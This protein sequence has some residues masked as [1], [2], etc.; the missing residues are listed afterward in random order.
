MNSQIA[1]LLEKFPAV[2]KNQP[3][4]SE[5]YAETVALIVTLD[6]L[7]TILQ[8]KSLGRARINLVKRIAAAYKIGM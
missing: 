7:K 8:D 6:I 3:K 5:K 2:G 4:E 1:S